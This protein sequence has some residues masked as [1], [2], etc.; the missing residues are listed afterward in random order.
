MYLSWR[1][2]QGNNLPIIHYGLGGGVGV[3]DE[4]VFEPLFDPPELD[5][6]PE[7]P[8]LDPPNPDPL[9]P[10]KLDPPNPDPLDPPKPDPPN[11]DVPFPFVPLAGSPPAPLLLPPVTIFIS[12]NGLYVNSHSL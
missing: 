9:D 11:P 10:P 3:G 2:H 1:D 7:L 4:V 8:K 5:P 6:L 12:L